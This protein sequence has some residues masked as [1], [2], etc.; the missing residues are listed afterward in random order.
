MEFAG[1]IPTLAL[2]LAALLSLE[3]VSPGAQPPPPIVLIYL[4][5]EPVP[6][7]EVVGGVGLGLTGTREVDLIEGQRAEISFELVNRV[8]QPAEVDLEAEVDPPLS[9]HLGDD[10]VV[11]P[12]GGN[13]SAS[14]EVSAPEGLSAPYSGTLRIVARE[15]GE[16][17][18][19]LDVAVR[20]IRL[21]RPSLTVD[22]D[23]EEAYP[24]QRCGVRISISNGG[25]LPLRGNLTVGAT[26][27]V[28]HP[29]G[30]L[31]EDAMTG[32]ADLPEIAPGESLSLSF[33]LE[34]P[35]RPGGP[36]SITANLSYGAGGEASAS[37]TVGLLLPEVEVSA[38]AEGGGLSLTVSNRGNGSATGVAVTLESAAPFNLTSASGIELERMGSSSYRIAAG[39][40]DPGGSLSIRLEGDL[41]PGQRIDILVNWTTPG[42]LPG[43]TSTGVIVGGGVGSVPRISDAAILAVV[44][45]AVLASAL[46][47]S[48]RRRART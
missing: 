43:G 14:V 37:A 6:R 25:D 35:T 11:V 10:H 13:A 7:S 18:G 5:Y 4:G 24:G 38:A 39:D 48:I 31:S 23:R 32:G 46:I 1:R 30:D 44:I 29:T 42:G 19:E 21:P 20:A 16:V 26:G 34:I 33:D 12:A 28:L 40:L 15:G 3:A 27:G 8:A 47:L 36:A 2:G 41:S 9:A 17:V 45:C 22:V